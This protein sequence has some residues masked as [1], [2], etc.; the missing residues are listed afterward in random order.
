MPTIIKKFYLLKYDK[1]VVALFQFLN[2]NFDVGL[3]MGIRNSW[4]CISSGGEEYSVKL[5]CLFHLDSFTYFEAGGF[6]KDN[7]T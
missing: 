4:N 7:S 1:F 5:C 6:F 3:M 2:L